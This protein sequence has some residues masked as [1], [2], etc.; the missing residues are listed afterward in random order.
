MEDSI[1]SFSSSTTNE[2]IPLSSIKNEE[3]TKTK[4]YQNKS[5]KTKTKKNLKFCS[6]KIGNIL[7]LFSDSKGNPKIMIGPDWPFFLLLWGGLTSVYIFIFIKYMTKLHLIISVFGI[8]SFL[9]F[10]IPYT[11]TFLLNNG[12]PERNEKSLIGEPRKKYQYCQVC[13]IWTRKDKNVEHCY[14]C[15]ICVEGYDH[16]CPWT[17]KCIG[18]KTINYFYCF[19]CSIF[20]VTLF[21]LC[22]MISIF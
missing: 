13:E 21:F 8:I 20:F 17:G 14:E 9:L 15:D 22:A 1:T 4:K 2:K 3:S 12:Y 11:A 5:K 10:F 16:H 19:I 7:C 6:K 18:E